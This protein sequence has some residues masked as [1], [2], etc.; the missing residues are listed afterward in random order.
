MGSFIDDF[1]ISQLCVVS[2]S[3]GELIYFAY[4]IE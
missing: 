1:S 3:S 4:T 2:V